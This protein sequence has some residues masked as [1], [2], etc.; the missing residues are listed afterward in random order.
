MATAIAAIARPGQ[1]LL[2]VRAPTT[3]GSSVRCSDSL[4]LPSSRSYGQ[5]PACPTLP[6][7]YTLS[8]P[9]THLHT[10]STAEGR[11]TATVP[12]INSLP[13]PNLQASPLRLTL[14][15]RNSSRSWRPLTSF[16][17]PNRP[18][19]API[20]LLPPP[21]SLRASSAPRFSPYRLRATHS[22]QISPFLSLP[23]CRRP[24]LFPIIIFFPNRVGV[25]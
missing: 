25:V 23:P 19:S 20:I 18:L 7:L 1:S 22:T 9:S 15:Q 8:G 13:P 4:T 11:T 2:P 21:S 5:V 24:H 16:V 3:V 17:L 12:Y 14:P 10:C 6:T